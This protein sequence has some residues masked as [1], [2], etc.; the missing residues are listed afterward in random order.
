MYH[1]LRSLGHHVVDYPQNHTF[2][3]R[4]VQPCKGDC[5]N[6]PCTIPGPVGCSNH[7]AHISML[8]LDAM[9]HKWDLVVTNNGYGHEK[10]HRAL[11]RAGVPIAAL[12]LGDS[13]SDSYNAWHKVIGSSNFSFFRREYY[14]GQ[15][16][17]PLPYSYY[18]VPELCEEKEHSVAFLY[19][20]T[21]PLR[22][23]LA[24]DIE[25]FPDAIIGEYPHYEYLQKI[26]RSK[27]AVAIRG[28]GWDT[29]RYW[30][31]PALGSV[32]CRQPSPIEI[33][34]DFQD[35]VNC[36]EFNTITELKEKIDYYIKRPAVYNKMRQDSLQHFQKFHTTEARARQLLEAVC[37][38]K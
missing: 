5:E 33:P 21:N 7:P 17:L 22:Q 2:H 20:P 23:Q 37:G 35:G 3:F 27:F 28:A 14:R 18:E 8:Y 34:N 12:D 16:G 32:L 19:R 29:L 11:S 24:A 15:P 31:I 13:P 26:A 9:D 10:L 25:D 30:E 38:G 36:V 4:V 6:G 1:G